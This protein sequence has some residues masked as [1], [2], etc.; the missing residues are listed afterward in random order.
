[1]CVLQLLVASN[2]AVMENIICFVSII[3]YLIKSLAGQSR[4]VLILY[5]NIVQRCFSQAV[6]DFPLLTL[7][8]K[9]LAQSKTKCGRVVHIV[10][11]LKKL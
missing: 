3:H 6:A 1:M 7:S 11:L 5:S 8:T 2:K 10:Q 4:I 9:Y